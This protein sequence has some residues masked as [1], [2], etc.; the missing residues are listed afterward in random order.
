MEY[1]IEH[2]SMGEVKVPA[3]KYWGAQTQRSVENFPIGVGLETMPRE[4]THAFGCLKK[5]AAMANYALRPE[6]MTAEKLDYISRACDEVISGSLNDHFPLVVWQTGSGTQ[7][8]MNTNEVIANRG[9]AIAGKKLLHPN[10]DVNMSQSSNDTFPTAMHI[11]AVLAL[12]E[13]VIPAIDV[14]TAAFARLER[15]NEGIVKS[16][17]THLQDATPITF[18]QEISGWRTSLERDKALIEASLPFLKELALGGTAVGTG[19]NAPKGFDTKVA[20]AVSELTGKSFITAP[21]KFHALTSK[22]ELVFAH[23]SLKA[24]AM[25]LIKIANDIRWL[26]SGPRLGLG[27]IIIPENEPGSSI[28]PGK[29]NPTQCEAVTMVAVQVLGNDA[30]IGFAASQGNFE[31]NV[32]MPVLIYN[33][34]QSAR[35]LGDSMLSFHDHCVAGIQANREKMRGNLHNSLMLVTALNP[36]IGYE[37]AARVAKK[38]YKEN[39]SLKEACV[40]LGYLTAEKFDAVFHPEEMV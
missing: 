17:R 21:N 32:F 38:A 27:E 14:L 26:S 7:S 5:A 3:D 6:K 12:E 33:F 1:R 29:V 15:E 18:S 23:G 24:L 13:K 22:D 39:T 8:N 36:H 28:M 11:A 34:L 4:I 19:L 16:G 25:D 30:A 2:D 40:S 35:L 9:N 37:N 31:L 20:E 10:D